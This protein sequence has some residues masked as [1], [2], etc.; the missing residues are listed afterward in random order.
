M[1]EVDYWVWI[2]IC[3]GIVVYVAGCYGVI[4]LLSNYVEDHPGIPARGARCARRL[5]GSGRKI[6]AHTGAHGPLGRSVRSRPSL[7]TLLSHMVMTA[8]MERR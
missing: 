7:P 5:T 2:V 6:G 1:A 4:R 3:A 8:V